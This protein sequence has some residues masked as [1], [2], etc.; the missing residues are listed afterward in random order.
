M[1]TWICILLG[2]GGLCVILMIIS[3][4]FRLMIGSILEGILEELID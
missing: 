3:E 1:S 2:L 4:R